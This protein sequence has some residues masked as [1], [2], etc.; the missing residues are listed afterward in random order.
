MD[1]L[2]TPAFKRIDFSNVDS[3]WKRE[4]TAGPAGSLM[5]EEEDGGSSSGKPGLQTPGSAATSQGTG[6]SPSYL[7]LS[8]PT[9]PQNRLSL[10]PTPPTR[11]ELDFVVLG[12]LGDGNFGQVVKAQ[13]RVDQA[14]YAV[15]IVK[16]TK[17]QVELKELRAHT[18]LLGC[19]HVVRYHT[20]WFGLDDDCLY[21]QLEL[22]DMTM[23]QA[24]AGLAGGAAVE[25]T[26]MQIC[27]H[28]ATALFYMHAKHLVHLDCKCDNILFASGVWK[29]GDLG[30]CTELSPTTGMPLSEVLDGDFT[31][32]ATEVVNDDYDFL[33]KAD[34][35]SLGLSL[36]EW[37][38]PSGQRLPAKGEEW[39]QL[40]QGQLPHACHMSPAFA[41]MVRW[42]VDGDVE[43]RCSVDQVLRWFQ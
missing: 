10:L 14:L 28:I 23:L 27:L 9:T 1:S 42:M 29:L 36:Y 20:S 25:A 43:R 21:I 11:L 16:R 4:R 31:Y 5:E 12:K 33:K 3:V 37:F 35:F 39:T 40:R 26:A 24:R 13:H 8:S 32:M 38:L 6:C 19:A 30:H 41:Q 22:C 34:V 2:T 18:L 15:K 17:R 7:F